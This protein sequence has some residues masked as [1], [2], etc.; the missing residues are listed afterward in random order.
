M[1]QSGK[2]VGYK[3]KPARG[4]A[5]AEINWQKSGKEVKPGEPRAVFS[6][7]LVPSLAFSFPL[8]HSCPIALI[9]TK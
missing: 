7:V 4:G 1:K 2:E 9:L 8:A 3:L 5:D 6:L